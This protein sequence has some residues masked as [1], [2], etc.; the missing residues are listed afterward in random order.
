MDKEEKEINEKLMSVYDSF[1]RKVQRTV[2]KII[3]AEKTKLHMGTPIG[4]YEE[5]IRIIKNEE[6]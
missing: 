4:I 5:I 1:S 6:K 2:K 3:D